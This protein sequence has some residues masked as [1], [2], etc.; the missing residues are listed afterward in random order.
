MKRH[1]RLD[2]GTY[3]N[4]DTNAAYIVSKAM[5]TPDCIITMK[6]PFWGWKEP[7]KICEKTNGKVTYFNDGLNI[8]K[9]FNKLRKEE[10]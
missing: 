6:H 5:E 9:V 3:L 4:H 10:K 8:P 7:Y 1:Y 2:N